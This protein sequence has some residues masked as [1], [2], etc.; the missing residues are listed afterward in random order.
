MLNSQR[1]PAEY[2]YCSLIARALATEGGHLAI[3]RGG[4]T[5]QY[6]Q[7]CFLSGYDCESLKAACIAAGLPVIDSRE[8]PFAVVCRLVVSGPMIAVGEPTSPEPWHA[9]SYVPLQA[10]AQAYREAGAEV[11]NL[12]LAGSD[13]SGREAEG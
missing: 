3:G 2:E 6:D 5:L 12:D 1:V 10:I 8:V 7:G 13:P 4:Y 11:F 9:L